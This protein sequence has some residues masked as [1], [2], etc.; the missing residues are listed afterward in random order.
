MRL[1]TW[2]PIAWRG[3]PGPLGHQACGGCHGG[4]AR[5]LGHEDR[6]RVGV[7]RQRNRTRQ[8]PALSAPGR[9]ERRRRLPG[10]LLH[11][12]A[13]DRDS[14]DVGR[15]VDRA[16]R[17]PPRPRSHRGHVRADVAPSRSEIHRY[18]RAL[19]PVRSGD[20]LRVRR[21]VVPRVCVLLAHRQ[22]LRPR[23]DGRGRPLPRRLPGRR[24]EPVLLE[25]AARVRI[26]PADLRAERVD[27]ARR[28]RA[29]G[30]SGLRC[31]RCRCSSCSRR[32]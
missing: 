16:L 14:A 8:L 31:G 5:A 7:G 27:P 17:R 15:V 18:A 23:L 25:P 22:L 32:S 20:V 30:S 26:L 6:S 21:V 24:E 1:R 19:H 2:Y 29:A 9:A 28:R 13:R 12:P 3:A 4:C 10:A 11:L